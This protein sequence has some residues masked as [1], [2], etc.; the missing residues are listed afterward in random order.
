[1]IVDSR[2]SLDLR[3]LNILYSRGPLLVFNG[4]IFIS[5]SS[6]NKGIYFFQTNGQL[7]N[8]KTSNINLF[9]SSIIDIKNSE[10]KNSSYFGFSV[11][12]NSSLS[13]FDSDILGGIYGGGI[14]ITNN[15]NLYLDNVNIE[16]KDGLGDGIGIYDGFNSNIEIR[17]S[18]IREVKD[19]IL[20]NN[21]ASVSIYNT[22]IN[23]SDM[24][25]SLY[26]ESAS[27]YLIEQQYCEDESDEYCEEE[28]GEVSLIGGSLS[29]FDSKIY[30]SSIAGIV[31]Y[32]GT[33]T[34]HNVTL[35]GNQIYENNFGLASYEANISGE[36]N[37]FYGNEIGAFNV[38]DIVNL[39]LVKNYWGDKTGP[40][41]SINPDGAGDRITDNILYVPFLNFDPTGEIRNPVILIPGITAT[42]LNRDYGDRGEIWPNLGRLLLS[43]DD[44]FLNDLALN[45]DGTE[46]IEYPIVV[47]DIIR[48][49]ATVDVFAGLIKEL[50]D[51]GYIEGED[52]FVFPYDWRF[53]TENIS[54]LLKEKI[55]EVLF[56]TNH[57]K[58]DIV[59]HSMGGLVAKKYISD[60]GEDKIDQLIFLGTP[61]LGVPKAFKVLM[62][63]DHMGYKFLF[64]NLNNL[65]AK[66]ISQ[67]MP[68]VYELLPSLKYLNLNGGYIFNFLDEVA[69]IG[70]DYNDTKKY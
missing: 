35:K 16:T 22:N 61:Q 3:G 46:N 39:N 43:P 59:A 6:F 1:M 53:S 21:N 15:S 49:I 44:S 38:N 11:Y 40:S 14:Y 8:I 67:N 41:H 66:F 2:S 70:L 26:G 50:T 56:K 60:N 69:D 20:I 52:L 47:G 10:I 4:N 48:E 36:Y 9:D 42:Y 24:G 19:G 63:G 65:R 51:A 13:V 58:V 62:F 18:E 32:D 55:D 54:I 68:S 27:S 45:E 57:E 23:A 64:M 29:I 37:S 31:I 17:D 30:G 5:E 34:V 33:D 28:I 12:E 7:E 25:V